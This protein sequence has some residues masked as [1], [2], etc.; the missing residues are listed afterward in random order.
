MIGD[1]PIKGKLIEMLKRLFRVGALRKPLEPSK[2]LEEQSDLMRLIAYHRRLD[3]GDTSS[4]D[5][6]IES[7]YPQG[8]RRD[9]CECQTYYEPPI[10][11]HIVQS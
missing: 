9:Y 7:K 10:Q 5:P 3:A 1:K 6:Y 11:D 2:P 8:R 4:V